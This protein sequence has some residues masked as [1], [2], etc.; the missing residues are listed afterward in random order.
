PRGAG[1]AAAGAGRVPLVRRV[2]LLCAVLAAVVVAG[3]GSGN[4]TPG[5][6]EEG[7]ST[8]TS[9]EA[10]AAETSEAPRVAIGTSTPGFD[11]TEVFEEASPGVVTIR[12]I[13][14]QG[15]AAEGSG[16]VLNLDGEIVTNAHVVTDE[17]SGSREPAE[18]VFVEF[19]DHNV[20]D[21][22]IVGFDPFADVALLKV[23]PNGF[24][25]HPLALGD[26]SNLKVGQP[27]AAIGSPFG[28]EQSLSV[29][30]VSATE[31]SVKSLTQFQI[32]GAI[33]TDASINPGNSG[34][35][36]LDAGAR[37][38]GINQQIETSSGANDG[39]GFAVPVSA[40]EHSIEQL[41]ENGKAEYAYLGI[42][43]ESLY[44]QLAEELDLDTDFGGLVAEVVPGGPA[45]KA[46]LEGGDEKL[47]FQGQPYRVGGDVILQIDG[48]PVVQ[49]DDPARFVAEHEPGEKVDLTVIHDGKRKQVEVRLEARPD[50]PDEG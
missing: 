45:D 10:T 25:L 49:V 43:T 16:F 1:A 46:G 35:P 31:R 34:G 42:S 24:E 40:I 17:S 20:V 23:E 13:F 15:S 22:E 36:L 30:V 8:A 4:A 26:D 21:A 9:A 6:D 28:E 50:T 2:L 47:V 19:P 33:Q 7:A 12:S 39:V 11:A 14:D 27:V 32:N 18:E 3:C 29:G 41:R 37:V 44:P 5:P 48:K 38:L